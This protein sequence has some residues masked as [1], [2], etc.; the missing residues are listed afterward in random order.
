MFKIHSVIVC[1]FIMFA[2]SISC[3]TGSSP[4]S[5]ISYT[6]DLNGTI[7]NPHFPEDDC[8][9]YNATVTITSN[10]G[11]YTDTTS[12]YS[13]SF[14]IYS[15][16]HNGSFTITV[17]VEGLPDYSYYEEVTT[18]ETSISDKVLELETTQYTQF[19]RIS[20]Y[21]GFSDL[22]GN[23][24]EDVSISTDNAH[25]EDYNYFYIFHSGTAAFTLS[26]DGYE[27][28]N[29]SYEG[30]D[31]NLSFDYM[32]MFSPSTPVT[33]VS[34]KVTFDNSD[35]IIS[36]AVVY[37][38]A[39][40]SIRTFTDSEG[41]YE[42]DIPHIQ[43]F[44]LYADA[45][46]MEASYSSI[47]TSDAEYVRNLE[48]EVDSMYWST[49]SGYA[50]EADGTTQIEGIEV[51]TG[52][53]SSVTGS[54][55]YSS[56]MGRYSGI[57]VRKGEAHT[58]TFNGVGYDDY[59][60]EV[61]DTNYSDY[62]SLNANMTAQTL[63]YPENFRVEDVTS[64]SFTLAWDSVE[65]ANGYRIFKSSSLNGTYTSYRS[66]SSLSYDITNL[67]PNNRYYYKI[68]AYNYNGDTPMSPALSVRTLS[69]TST[70]LSGYVRY[71]DTN[72]LVTS[73]TLVV[74][75][76]AQNATVTSGQYSITLDPSLTDGVITI[77]AGG[78]IG[79]NS[80][81]ATTDAQSNTESHNIYLIPTLGSAIS[82]SVS[83]YITDSASGSTPEDIENLTVSVNGSVATVNT[84]TGYYTCT[85]PVNLGAL[86]IMVGGSSSYSTYIRTIAADGSTK[87]YDIEL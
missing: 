51:S 71:Q 14:H 1:V 85:T 39:D 68:V 38:G 73:G 40:P 48:V 24:I 8:D 22:Y 79:Y 27:T 78:V 11:T 53:F 25:S 34:G 54:D 18:Q 12:G 50:Y 62:L 47:D 58:L 3:G 26:A 74:S 75:C 20:T 81:M 60:I 6:T 76:N 33:N 72:S 83:G 43:S 61:P 32:K 5:S 19:V 37:Y 59:T 64:N 84:N 29:L 46:T 42:L 15:I 80:Y 9:V 2:F 45:D 35:T 69:P 77:Q 67:T 70:T 36:D 21:T 7:I 4:D 57:Y 17:S 86:T 30:I 44:N 28:R 23:T 63:S 16:V 87:T 82:T 56:Q 31:G 52:D 55:Q 49:I 10:E 41:N 66:T 65:G 13:N